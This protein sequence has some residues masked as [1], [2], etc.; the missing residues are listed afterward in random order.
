MIIIPGALIAIVTFPGVIVHE[1]AHLFFCRLRKVPVFDA[2]FFQFDMTTAGYVIH[3]RSDNFTTEFL[4]STGPFI[5]NTLLCFFI[6]LPASVPYYYF[7][8]LPGFSVLLLWLGISI[9][10]HAFPSTVDANNIWMLAKA[11]ARKRNILAILSFPIVILI[12]FANALKFMW[13]D[14][15]FGLG[16]GVGLPALI[17][18]ALQ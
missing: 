4:I 13:F 2:K 8:E 16:I 5:I 1:A 12:Y 11:E 15:L 10:M 18:S 6:C 14:A 7:D 17:L 3:G 9:G